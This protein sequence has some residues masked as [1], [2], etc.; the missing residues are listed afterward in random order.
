MPDY[1]NLMEQT[2]TNIIVYLIP[3][4]IKDKEQP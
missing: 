2:Q 1:N 3:Y 4:K